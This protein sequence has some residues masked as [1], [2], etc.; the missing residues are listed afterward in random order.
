MQDAL[1][2]C[3]LYE[4]KSFVNG[5]VIMRCID[6]KMNDLLRSQMPAEFLPALARLQALL[7]YQIMRFFDGD[8]LA[9][10]S[11]DA[12][13]KELRS[14]A[15]ALAGHIIWAH[16]SVQESVQRAGPELE[17]PCPT[18]QDSRRFWKDWLLQESARRTFLIACFFMNVWK[19]LTGRQVETCR[20]DP[21]L[22]GQSWTLSAHLWQARDCFDF[23]VAWGEKHHYVVRR[24]AII[25]TLAD[26]NGDDIEDFGKM[27]LTV[28]MGIEEAKAWLAAKGTSLCVA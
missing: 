17:A 25:S 1:S 12:T 10:S 7:L 2:A 19:L 13:F 14:S 24:K 16:P 20:G 15:N 22:L 6:A 18:L 3:A 27:L 11:A 23:A 28:S 21:I 26:A 8:V 4:S 5:P 9:R